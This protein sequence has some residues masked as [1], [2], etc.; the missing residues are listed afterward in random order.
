MALTNT[1]VQVRVKN[2]AFRRGRWREYRFA[3][4]GM[5]DAADL[6]SGV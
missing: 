1:D 6:P 4:A 3:Q 5:L 2:V